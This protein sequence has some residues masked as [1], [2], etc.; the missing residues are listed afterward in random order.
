MVFMIPLFIL[1]FLTVI[2]AALPYFVKRTITFGVTIPEQYIHDERLS[3][4]KRKYTVLSSISSLLLILIFCFW[5]L[6]RSPAED[7]LIFISTVIEFGIIFISLALYFYFHGKTKAY[8]TEMQW[9]EQLKQ[10]GVVDLSARSEDSLPPWYIYLFPM[11]ITLGLMGYTIFQY[12]LLPDEIPTHWGPTGEPDAFTEK[13]PFSAI[14]LLLFLLL[15]QLMFLG[16][17]FGMKSSG[18]K[19]STTNLAASKNRQ[20]ILRRLSS[21]FSFFT[22]LLITMLFSFF[23]ITIIHPGLFSNSI[24]TIIIPFG[25]M[26]LILAGTVILVLKV[27]RSD[28]SSQVLVEDPIMDV[29][30][31]RYWKGG[32]FYF[33]K[34][35][36]SIFVEKRFGVGWTINLANPIGYFILFVPLV[37]ILILAFV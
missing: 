31:D 32:L 18:I 27:G 3:A 37:I 11:I 22:V 15:L 21:W 2:Q 5:I 23:Q 1:L 7:V 13:S 6:W 19:L 36:P 20:F 12:N 16:I 25:T 24:L 28:K 17:Q 10:V 29:D 34:N 33:N 30:E 8:K 26:I 9:T 35:D 14:Q 4:Y